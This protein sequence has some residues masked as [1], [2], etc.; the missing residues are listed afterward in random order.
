M[1]TVSLIWPDGSIVS[2]RSYAEVE[3]A[4]RASQWTTYPSRRAF[5]REMR[6]RA[7]LWTGRRLSKP[8]SW[9]TSKSFI[10]SLVDSGMCMLDETPSRQEIGHE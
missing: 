7:V 4:L 6:K 1:K 8:I 3:D 9:Q 10:H 2:G 5:R